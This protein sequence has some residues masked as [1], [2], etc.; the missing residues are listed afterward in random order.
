MTVSVPA[1]VPATVPARTVETI[2]SAAITPC[3][4]ATKKARNFGLSFAFHAG[5]IQ[6]PYFD[7]SDTL[8]PDER[9]CIK[10]VVRG[11]TPSQI[12]SGVADYHVRAD[13]HGVV[14]R[15]RPGR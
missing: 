4:T 12:P 8:S 3:L 14:L 11:L 15:A 7:G 5:S 13:A 6:K 2:V 10:H 1:M 9:G